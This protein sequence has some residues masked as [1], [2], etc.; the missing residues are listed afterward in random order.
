MSGTIVI[1]VR[2][3]HILRSQTGGPNSPRARRP[4]PV[5]WTRPGPVDQTRPRPG[6]RKGKPAKGYGECR[7]Q[8]YPAVACWQAAGGLSSVHPAAPAVRAG[9]GLSAD[10][11]ARAQPPLSLARARRALAY[12][13]E[14]WGWRRRPIPKRGQ[15]LLSV[16]VL[17]DESRRPAGVG[18]QRSAIARLRA[19]GRRAARAHEARVHSTERGPTPCG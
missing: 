6:L 7:I 9:H 11:D 17:R 12:F 13:A 8:G 2:P 3:S 15:G 16:G 10:A 1:R 5:R 4:G 19:G 18:K 14:R